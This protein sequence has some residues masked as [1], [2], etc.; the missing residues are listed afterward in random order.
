MMAHAI[1]YHLRKIR[2]DNCGPC[3]VMMTVDAQFGCI[4]RKFISK[5]PDI[6]QQRGNNQFLTRACLFGQ[7]RTLIHML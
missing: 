4:I 5:M 7:L 1:C 6:M 2:G 3:P